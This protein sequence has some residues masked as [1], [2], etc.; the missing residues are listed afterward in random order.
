MLLNALQDKGRNPVGILAILNHT[1]WRDDGTVES[2]K[3]LTAD[4]IKQAIAGPEVNALPNKQPDT[5]TIDEQQQ[6]FID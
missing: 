1:I 5:I 4:E 3:Q 6:A 2:V